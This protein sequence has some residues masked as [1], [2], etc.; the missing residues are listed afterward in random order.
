MYMYRKISK[1][2]AFSLIR[3]E[4]RGCCRHTG[5]R[6]VRYRKS[7]MSRKRIIIF[8]FSPPVLSAVVS[9][10]YSVFG[11]VLTQLFE[12]TQ[13]YSVRQEYFQ[14]DCRI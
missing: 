3:I 4:Q 12:L 14:I 1:S 10:K 5:K 13:L 8:K 6:R 9:K 2:F 11:R 7:C